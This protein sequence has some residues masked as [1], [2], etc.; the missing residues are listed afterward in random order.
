[1]WSQIINNFY[2][3]PSYRNPYYFIH[4]V[5][6]ATEDIDGELFSKNTS[7]TNPYTLKDSSKDATLNNSRGTDPTVI[8]EKIPIDNENTTNGE[9]LTLS[10]LS[11]IVNK[12]EGSEIE[13]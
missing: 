9:K 4:N 10:G 7:P 11:R 1:M 8:V 5:N 6:P 13:D 12:I 2:M 3:R